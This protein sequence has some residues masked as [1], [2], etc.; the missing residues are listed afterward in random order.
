MAVTERIYQSLAA[1]YCA[2]LVGPVVPV[3]ASW[4]GV[5]A[6]RWVLFSLGALVAGGL[7][8][9]AAGKVD[10]VR[11]L[12]TQGPAIAVTLLPLS[13]LVWLIALLAHNPTR[14]LLT[15][16]VRP[17]T[18]GVFAFAI[19]LVGVLLAS[20]QQTVE[21]IEASTVYES[22]T[23]RPAPGRRRLR[24]WSFAG[25]LG[26]IAG[27]LLVLSFEGAISVALLVAILV[28]VP[29]AVVGLQAIH[30]QSVV[31]TDRGVAVDGT[32]TEWGWFD[33]YEVTDRSL[34]LEFRSGWTGQMAFD[35]SDIPS[36]DSL[37]EILDDCVDQQ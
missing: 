19:G 10:L 9:L 26:S 27:L 12:P 15:I 37:T 32:F 23:A 3:V 22:F 16:F 25:G 5:T 2:L 35:R 17:S 13:Y 14:S 8:Y 6:Y 36:L 34:V 30:A 31:V 28:V 18:A 4:G 11:L 29:M 20:R 21:N 33:D 24:Y 1:S 7:G